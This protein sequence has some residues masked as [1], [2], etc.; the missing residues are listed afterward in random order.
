MEH[1]YLAILDAIGNFAVL[2]VV[3]VLFVR[4]DIF[5][6]K[7]TTAIIAETVTKVLDQLE[8]RGLMRHS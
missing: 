8:E 1:D 3:F 6:S 7:T 2:V 4:G 5:S